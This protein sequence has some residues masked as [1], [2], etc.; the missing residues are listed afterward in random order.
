MKIL[1]IGSGAR[2]HTIAWKL[3]HSPRTTELLVAPGNAGTVRLGQNVSI[4]A[5]DV[6]GLLRFAQEAGI[7]LTVV[8]PEAPLAAGISDRFQQAGLTIF[9]P[10]KEAALIESSKSFAKG[11]MVEH[12][13]PTGRARIFSSYNEAGTH[14]SSLTLPIVIKADGPGGGQRGNRGRDPRTGA[15]G[16]AHDFGG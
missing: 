8:G 16:P 5:T 7:D 10:T 12:G 14:I 9:G 4:E 1:V 13:V 3:H 15:R 6:E 11:L 2:E